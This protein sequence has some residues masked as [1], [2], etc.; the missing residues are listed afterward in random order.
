MRKLSLV[1]FLVVGTGLIFA[2]TAGKVSGTVTDENGQPLAGANVIVVG[3]AFGGASD[4]DGNYYIL[5]IPAGV[6]EVRA[7][8]IGYKSET[9]GDVR[10]S[11]GLTTFIDYGLAIAAVEGESVEVIGERPLLEMSATN[12][13]RSMD[14]DQIANFS[15][16]NVDDMIQ[17]QAGVVEHNSEIHLRGSRGSEVGYTLDG[18]ST[19]AVRSFNN[20]DGSDYN[21]INAIP[22]ALQEVSVQSG[23]Y[24]AELGGANAGIVQQTMR[25]G[26]RNLSGTIGYAT[27]GMAETFDTDKLGLKDFTFTLG[28]PITEKIRFFGA[29]RMAGTDNYRHQWWDGAVINADE[30]GDPIPILDT[31]SP[32]ANPVSYAVVMPDEIEGRTQTEHLLNGTLLFDFNPL[33]IRASGAYTNRT[34]R[35]NNNPSFNMW[36]LKRQREN[37]WDIMLGS[38]KGTYFLNSKTYLHLAVS[39]LDRQYEGYD[40]NFDHDN[41]ADI[42][43]YGDGDIVDFTVGQ[44][45]TLS[46][47]LILLERVQELHALDGRL[48]GHAGEVRVCSTIL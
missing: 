48:L 39:A 31:N 45:A 9:I 26:G 25:T 6:Y 17:A 3:S 21:I 44:H 29:Y 30:N 1:L 2:Q 24:S 34:S 27:D 19:K 38:L 32:T 35:N 47:D 36:N 10:V 46:N 23:G 28:G 37:N 11:T 43:E 41:L 13:V 5:Q 22:E 42:L 7:D 18:V 12:A 20:Q 15:S 4:S 16:R 8:Y 14:S 33:V 40:P